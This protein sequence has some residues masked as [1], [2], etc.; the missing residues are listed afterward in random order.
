MRFELEVVIIVMY[1][2]EGGPLLAELS[3]I[4]GKVVEPA[5]RNEQSP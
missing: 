1:V 4:D 2:S 5:W 3:P